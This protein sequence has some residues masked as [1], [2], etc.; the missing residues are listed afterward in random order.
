MKLF[1]IASVIAL[2]S[3]LVSGSTTHLHRRGLPSIFGEGSELLDETSVSHGGKTI[4]VSTGTYPPTKRDTT[5]SKRSAINIDKR[6]NI[7]TDSACTLTCV[8]STKAA[9]SVAD[10]TTLIDYIASYAPGNF[11]LGT[12]ELKRLDLRH[13]RNRI[14]EL[15]YSLIHNLL[16]LSRLP[17][18]SERRQQPSALVAAGLMTI[19]WSRKCNVPTGRPPQRS[20]C[21][22][23]TCHKLITSG[24][25]CQNIVMLCY[26]S[27]LEVEWLS[28]IPHVLDK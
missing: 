18:A 28:W 23:Q 17:N 15:R 10:C 1:F 5:V 12:G 3:I 16:W 20:Q 7:C 21:L 9:K 8:T 26:R 13:L 24:L 14:C 6:Q 25:V 11:T 27:R 19:M 4:L 2:S 22:F